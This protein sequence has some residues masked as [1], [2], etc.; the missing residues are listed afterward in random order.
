M[1]HQAILL[2]IQNSSKYIL[3][4]I[5]SFFLNNKLCLFREYFVEKWI[6]NSIEVNKY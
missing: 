6:I 3:N 4:Y 1:N 2:V 5:V